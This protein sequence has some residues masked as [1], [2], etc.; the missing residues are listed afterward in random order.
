MKIVASI[1]YFDDFES[2]KNIFKNIYKNIHIFEI[3]VLFSECE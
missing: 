2:Q 1:L 3:L